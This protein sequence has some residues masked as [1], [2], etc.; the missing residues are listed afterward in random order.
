MAL[1]TLDGTPVKRAEI[2][3]PYCGVWTA[4]VQLDRTVGIQSSVVLTVGGLVMKGTVYRA[5]DFLGTTS[6]RI[7]GGNGAWSRTLPPVYYKSAFGVNS[8]LIAR[9]AALFCGESLSMDLVD[10]RPLGEMFVL[11]SC[12]ASRLLDQVCDLWYVRADGVTRIGSRDNAMIVSKFDVLPD[13]TD[14][15]RGRITLATD[16]PEDWVPGRRFSCL[17]FADVQT[18]SSVVHR[19]DAGKLRTEV[20]T[21]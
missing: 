9:A 20:W 14:P 3:L 19:L 4:D 10:S 6:F 17:Q 8:I 21:S 2:T 16:F 13:G 12:P 11:A 7:V 5:G 15:G 1:A 18:I